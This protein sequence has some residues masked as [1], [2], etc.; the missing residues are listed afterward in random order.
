MAREREG[1]ARGSWEQHQHGKEDIEKE[2][3]TGHMANVI[4]MLMTTKTLRQQHGGHGPEGAASAK[5]G[6]SWKAQS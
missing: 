2:K 3:E 5:Q 4:T 6:A 1:K